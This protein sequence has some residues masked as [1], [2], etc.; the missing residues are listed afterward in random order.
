[1]PAA[2]TVTKSGSEP[3][4]IWLG[5]GTLTIAKKK[6][7]GQT[8]AAKAAKAAARGPWISLARK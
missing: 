7:A 2:T 5:Y 3:K 8:A 6:R 4:Y 1:M